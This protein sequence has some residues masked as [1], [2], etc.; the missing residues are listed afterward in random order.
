MIPQ[1]TFWDIVL[2]CPY[3]T[4]CGNCR[5]KNIGVCEESDGRVTVEICGLTL[6]E[7]EKYGPVIP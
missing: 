4:D 7:R 6:A 5:N 1:C 2:K 3:R